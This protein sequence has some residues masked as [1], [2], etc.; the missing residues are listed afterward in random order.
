M[1]GHSF[2]LLLSAAALTMGM[3]KTSKSFASL[4]A[5]AQQDANNHQARHGTG[6][7]EDCSANVAVVWVQSGWCTY[8]SFCP[9]PPNVSLTDAKQ[10]FCCSASFG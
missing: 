1:V 4:P 6:G 9:L 5:T 10:L 3:Q 7:K 2:N 8:R